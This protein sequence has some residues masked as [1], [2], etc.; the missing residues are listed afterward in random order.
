MQRIKD[1]Y[2]GPEK[3]QEN[4]AEMNNNKFIIKNHSKFKEKAALLRK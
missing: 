3:I 1:Y 2:K 4:I